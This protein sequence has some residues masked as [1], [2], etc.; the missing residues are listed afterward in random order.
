MRVYLCIS[1]C[2]LYGNHTLIMNIELG[3]SQVK[4]Q[5]ESSMELDSFKTRDNGNV[6]SWKGNINFHQLDLIDSKEKST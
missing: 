5:L 3:M 1:N 2:V 4:T 6:S